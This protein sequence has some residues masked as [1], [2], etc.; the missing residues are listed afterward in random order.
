LEYSNDARVLG[1]TSR[2]MVA[3]SIAFLRKDKVNWMN[4][5]QYDYIISETTRTA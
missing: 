3:V 2:E 4:V 5:Y 1:V